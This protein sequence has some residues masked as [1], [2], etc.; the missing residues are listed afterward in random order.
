MSQDARND[1]QA[2]DNSLQFDLELAEKNWAKV[3]Q[4]YWTAAL[5]Q[6]GKTGKEGKCK[7]N[8]SKDNGY[9]ELRNCGQQGHPAR[10]C[11][12]AGK[13]H[14]GVGATDGSKRA[15]M[16]AVVKGKGK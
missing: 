2:E 6:K 7:G 1:Q 10:D 9:G 3:E 16:A 15:G 5:G 11:P 13:L 14:V 12:V 8:T 4:E